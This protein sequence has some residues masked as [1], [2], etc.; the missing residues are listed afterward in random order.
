MAPRMP[1]RNCSLVMCE[2]A[3]PITAKG[4]GRTRP[5]NIDQSAGTS[6][7]L[8]RSPEAPKM[9]RVQ[10]SSAIAGLMISGAFLSQL[11][12]RR[13]QQVQQ[14]LERLGRLPQQVQADDAASALAKGL[15]IAEGLGGLEDREVVARSGDRQ[16]LLVR[17]RDLDEESAGHWGSRRVLVHWASR[18]AVLSLARATS[19]SSNGFTP[20]IAPAVAVA[21]SQRKNSPATSSGSLGSSRITGC[22]ALPSSSSAASWL[23]SP[24][25]VSATKRRSAPYTA[26]LPGGSSSTGTTPLPSLPR[27]SARSCSSQGPSA[28]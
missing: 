24:S 4:S 12:G 10:E 20:R 28:L 7:R 17:S 25:S 8:A 5:W 19:G 27:D 2:R 26:G 16:L 22:P 1:G 23:R 15:E 6:L 14:L 18:R 11:P 3:T 21:S 9:T 13:A